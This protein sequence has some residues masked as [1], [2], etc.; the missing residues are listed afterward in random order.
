MSACSSTERGSY[1]QEHSEIAQHK[2]AIRQDHVVGKFDI[3]TFGG[4]DIMETKSRYENGGKGPIYIATGRDTLSSDD[5]LKRNQTKINEIA[6]KFN[7]A[8]I[9]NTLISVI[10]VEKAN[11]DLLV[12]GFDIE[13]FGMSEECRTPNMPGYY[14][15]TR[16]EMEGYKL[17]CQNSLLAMRQI[18]DVEDLKKGQEGLADAPDGERITNVIAGG[19][20]PGETREFIPSYIV[21]DIGAN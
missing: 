16:V 2:Y 19:Y 1:L 12:I 17:G 10:D 6:D 20:N 18:S 21:S 15:E 13:H 4:T 9:H 8:G 14:G 11:P 7:R 5:I 3:K